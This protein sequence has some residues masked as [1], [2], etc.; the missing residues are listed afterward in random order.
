MSISIALLGLHMLIVFFHCLILIIT[1]RTSE[2]WN[3]FTDIVAL[4]FNSTP[5]GDALE[6]CGTSVMLEE[7]LKQKVRVRAV[8]NDENIKRKVELVF[9]SGPVG[10]VGSEE[11]GADL[12]LAGIDGGRRYG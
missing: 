9:S 1:A 10:T 7:T 6:N 11:G 5:R 3:S 4:A 8:R 2:A 12:N